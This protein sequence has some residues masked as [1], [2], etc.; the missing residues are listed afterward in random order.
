MRNDN[1]V[2]ILL[3]VFV[4]FGFGGLNLLGRI[5]AMEPVGAGDE[6]DLFLSVNNPTDSDMD[7]MSVK[8]IFFDLGEYAVSGEFDLEDGSSE[9]IVLNV[10]IPSY[11]PKGDHLVKIVASNDDYYDSKFIYVNI[12]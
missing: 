9:G 8:A 6:L 12:V 2:S 4:V 3:I 5:N 10:D 1:V 11:A 7:G